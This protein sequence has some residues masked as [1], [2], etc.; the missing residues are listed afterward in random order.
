MPLFNSSSGFQVHGGNFY[1]V[2]GDMNIHSTRP[3]MARIR[4]DADPLA[5][6]ESDLNSSRRQLLGADR[7][8][9]RTEAARTSP[10][11]RSRRPPLIKSDGQPSSTRRVRLAL[12]PPRSSP[13]A[14]SLSQG[15][16][17]PTA[18]RPFSENSSRS[19][20]PVDPE[21][22]RDRH[23]AS[24]SH[25]VCPPLPADRHQ[26]S[27]NIGG[28]VNQIQRRGELGLHILHSA[29]AGDAL[30][31]S[32]E[33]YPQPKCHPE[34]R[35]EM[36]E[37]LWKWSSSGWS[38]SV[39]WLHGPA[40]AGKSAIAQSFCQKLEE[41]HCLGASFFFKRGDPSRGTGNCF[42]RLPISSASVSRN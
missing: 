39:L 12:L 32:A 4:Q 25:I 28:N 3:P 30:H 21:R 5:A 9:R 1:E 11:G 42:L 20:T 38:N 41:E 35:T 7:N 8:A 40:G 16:T 19:V 10:Y 6:L 24:D 37:D 27:I 2:A 33:R 17:P 14:S 29:I 26:T 13:L 15:N 23:S 22:S 18:R 31:D 36:H 34:T